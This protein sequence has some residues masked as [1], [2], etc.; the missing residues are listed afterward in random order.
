MI[1][2]LHSMIITLFTKYHIPKVWSIAN[3]CFLIQNN[4][5]GNVLVTWPVANTCFPTQYMK[6]DIYLRHVGL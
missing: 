5:V 2:I 1:L 6:P 3:T 4:E